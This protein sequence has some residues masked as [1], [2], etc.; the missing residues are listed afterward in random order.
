MFIDEGPSVSPVLEVLE[1]HIK[2]VTE[3]APFKR[4]SNDEPV[5]NYEQFGSINERATHEKLS[6]L[7]LNGRL[8]GCVPVTVLVRQSQ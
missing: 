4:W 7:S 8:T 1:I 6:K 2:R 3:N 5:A